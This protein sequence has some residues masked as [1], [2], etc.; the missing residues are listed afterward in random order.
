MLTLGD[1][2]RATWKIGA[3]TFDGT[4]LDPDIRYFDATSCSVHMVDVYNGET[5]E[6][7]N[8]FVFNLHDSWSTYRQANAARANLDAAGVKHI[9]QHPNMKLK[10]CP[11]NGTPFVM[12]WS[13]ISKTY[14]SEW[15][16]FRDYVVNG[17]R[18]QHWNWDAGSRIK[19]SHITGRNL[20]TDAT[21]S[22]W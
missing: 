15:N 14:E 13:P 18:H 4:R 3:Y 20:T 19:Y 12:Y 21:A 5:G 22:D 8:R 9:P 6:K 10:V 1:I 17:I 11:Y 16:D 2:T 7:V